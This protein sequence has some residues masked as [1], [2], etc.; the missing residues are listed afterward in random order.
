MGF[1]LAAAS[2]GY[3]LVAGHR[4]LISGASL[5]AE[6]GRQ[7]TGSV[8]VAHG[9]SCSMAHGIFPDQGSNCVSYIGRWILLPLSQQGSPINFLSSYL[10]I[11]LCHVLAVAHRISDICSHMQD[12]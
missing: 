3:C 8:A 10:F 2:G 5:I 6:H 12:F 11:W 4:L 9:H 1:S 7:D